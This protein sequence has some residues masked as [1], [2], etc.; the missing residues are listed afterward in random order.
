[1]PSLVNTEV[2]V[3]NGARMAPARLL[4]AA[5]FRPELLIVLAVAQGIAIEIADLSIGEPLVFADRSGELGRENIVETGERIVIMRSVAGLD[6]LEEGAGSVLL[7]HAEQGDE[8]PKHPALP[9]TYSASA[10]APAA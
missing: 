9:G 7:A 2:D 6:L 4:E 3:D 5:D 8:K 1:M 10:L